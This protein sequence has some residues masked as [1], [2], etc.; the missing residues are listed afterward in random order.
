LHF[1]LIHLLILN[2]LPKY[3]KTTDCYVFINCY[4]PTDGIQ[5]MSWSR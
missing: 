5:G 4:E 1:S 2:N 3:H